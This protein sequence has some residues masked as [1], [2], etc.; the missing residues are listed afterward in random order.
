MFILDGTERGFLQKKHEEAIR[1]SEIQ[2]EV[3]TWAWKNF[4]EKAGGINPHVGMIEEVGELAKAILKKDQGIRGDAKKHD[5]DAIDAIGDIMVYMMNFLN[6]A[7]LDVLEL[8]AAT[9]AHRLSV[10]H[11]YPKSENEMS[12]FRKDGVRVAANC[13]SNLHTPKQILE[14]RSL[15][16]IDLLHN[17]V[18]T[19]GVISM[20]YGYGLLE[21]LEKTWDIV[22]KRDWV[23]DSEK[24][25]G[26][27]HDT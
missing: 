17:L 8:Y 24:G 2:R 6:S 3:G 7:R 12:E 27:T 19:L 21:V 20:S 11:R 23:A 16:D 10:S 13:I 25:G 5:S 9:W 18:S 14:Y 22:K 26:Y 15:S 1:M 4:G